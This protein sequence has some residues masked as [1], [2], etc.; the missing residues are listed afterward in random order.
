MERHGFIH[1]MGDTKVL[2]LYTMN[3]VHYPVTDQEI[4]ELS[5]WDECLSY[6]DVKIAIP[7]MVESGHLIQEGDKFAISDMGREAC[8]LVQTALAY[9]VAQRVLKAV[10]AYNEDIRRRDVLK[11][12]LESHSE[13]TYSVSMEL[14]GKLGKEFAMEFLVDSDEEAESLE[15]A[16]R[17]H[18]EEIYETIKS[19]LLDEI[20]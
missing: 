16:M 7:E 11:T 17:E 20:V 4:F 9:P 18:G 12:G 13:G 19:L 15:T 14:K 5:F 10:N 3:H 1:S 8:A 6:I 2:I